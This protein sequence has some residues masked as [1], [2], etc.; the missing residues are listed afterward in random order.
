MSVSSWEAH[1]GQVY[2]FSKNLIPLKLI[3]YFKLVNLPIYFM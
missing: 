2:I 1:N 3:N